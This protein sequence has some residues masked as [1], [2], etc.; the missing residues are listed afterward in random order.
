MLSVKGIV[1]ALLGDGARATEAF[2]QAFAVRDASLPFALTAAE[3][4]V[5]SLPCAR[6]LCAR[7]GLAVAGRMG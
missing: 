3:P 7:M 5:Q 1:Y 4:A 6:E 2:E